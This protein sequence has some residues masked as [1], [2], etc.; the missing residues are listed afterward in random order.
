MIQFL[1]KR[2][3]TK[4]STN[5]IAENLLFNSEIILKCIITSLFN[6]EM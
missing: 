3:S 6:F 4:R 1:I 5:Q 2:S